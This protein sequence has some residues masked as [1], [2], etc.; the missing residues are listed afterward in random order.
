MVDMYAHAY[1]SISVN[2]S[3]CMCVHVCIHVCLHVCMCIWVC[4]Y[5]NVCKGVFACGHAYCME[6]GSASLKTAFIESCHSLKKLVKYR[7]TEQ[8]SHL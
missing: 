8:P 2:I 7:P 5:M 3:I 4:V 1:V 6:R